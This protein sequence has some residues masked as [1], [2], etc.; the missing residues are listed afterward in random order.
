M[1]R[2]KNN[3]KNDRIL[4]PKRTI[5]KDEKK[6]MG[7]MHARCVLNKTYGEYGQ[8]FKNYNQYVNPIIM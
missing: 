4:Q 5:E 7:R 8:K 3:V 6:T 2:R 1:E